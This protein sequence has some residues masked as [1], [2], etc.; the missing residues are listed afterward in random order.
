MTDKRKG[1]LIKGII[2]S[3]LPG[4]IKYGYELSRRGISMEG[5]ITHQY[6]EEIA[7]AMTEVML[8]ALNDLEKLR[9]NT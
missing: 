8:T 4:A 5:S 7:N 3:S 2:K 1:F 9:K 6:S